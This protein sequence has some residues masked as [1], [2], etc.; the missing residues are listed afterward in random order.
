M[1]LPTRDQ[2]N[3]EV[4]RQF[5]EQYPQAPERLDPD[6]AAWVNAWLGIRDQVLNAWTDEVLFRFFP[7]A[8]Q[9]D[10]NN[11]ND[12]QLIEYWTD[13]RDQ[14]RDGVSGRWSWDDGAT[15]G[16][17]V[18]SLDHDL[19]GGW[20]VTF[21]QA[22]SV[23]QAVGYLWSG[24][25]PD[26]VQITADAPE[27]IHL[28]GLSIDALQTMPPEV[29]NRISAD[30]LTADPPGGQSGDPSSGGQPGP[31]DVH[32]EMD[33]TTKQQIAEWTER[34]LHGEHAL[35][36]TVEVTEYLSEAVAHLSGPASRAALVSEA[37][38]EVM[39]VL[40]PVS[41]VLFIIWVGF[42]VVDAFKA[43][44][45]Q[46]KMQGS[47]YGVMWQ[48]LDQPDR[49]PQFIDGITFSAEELREAFQ[50]G[51]AEGRAKASDPVVRNQIILAVAT[52]GVTSGLGDFY[53][54]TE[55]LSQLWRANREHSPGDRDTDKLQWPQPFDRH[56]F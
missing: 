33:E 53:A 27:K 13:I 26:G 4:D 40:G 37:V 15:T 38:G 22:V 23:D 35:A 47:V 34:A 39:T 51:V 19:S 31:T 49:L 43:E 9:L 42:E 5:R 41:D 55:V 44:R 36:S 14:I 56:W 17:S 30:V 11:P 6:Q 18:T 3:A 29:A 10:P 8:G 48:A 7:D 32:V 46:E 54:A 12:A 2:L 45:R 21:N 24:G 52:L 16:I 25:V 20:V 50:E 1:A 28:R